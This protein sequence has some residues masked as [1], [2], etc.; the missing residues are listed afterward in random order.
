MDFANFNFAPFIV[1][2]VLGLILVI[3][4]EKIGSSAAG[5]GG[6]GTHFGG[7]SGEDKDAAENLV[8]FVSDKTASVTNAARNRHQRESSQR[9]LIRQIKIAGLIAGFGIIV[10]LSSL[11]GLLD[12]A[13]QE[14]DSDNVITIILPAAGLIM[15]IVFSIAFSIR[16]F[17]LKHTYELYYGS[18]IGKK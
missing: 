11:F 18:I 14:I 3:A 4:I 10:A 16:F 15:G 2:I 8:Q 1:F 9:N 6:G 17:Q 5:G 13:G 7:G 12:A